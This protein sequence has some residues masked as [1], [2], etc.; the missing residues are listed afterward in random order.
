MCWISMKGQMKLMNK[1]SSVFVTSSRDFGLELHVSTMNEPTNDDVTNQAQRHDPLNAANNESKQSNL[2]MKCFV[3]FL[4]T[5]LIG[6]YHLAQEEFDYLYSTVNKKE[7]TPISPTRK[8]L[9]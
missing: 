5:S 7:K 1:T 4:P 6:F 2:S 3:S 9:K 8:S